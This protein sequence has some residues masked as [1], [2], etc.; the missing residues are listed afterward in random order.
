MGVRKGEASFYAQGRAR[1]KVER[2][3]MRGREG[4][5]ERE[6]TGELRKIETGIGE[7]VDYMRVRKGEERR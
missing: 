5:S 1:D 7:G 6:D 4:T 2:Q 3:V